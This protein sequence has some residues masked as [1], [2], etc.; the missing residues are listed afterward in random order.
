M[1][2]RQL[3]YL[4]VAA[5][6]II[7]IASWLGF[8]RKPGGEPSAPL[9]PELKGQ[10]AKVTAVKIYKGNEQLLVEAARGESGW[11]IKQ[12]FDYAGD[13]SKINGLLLAL[14][15]ATLLEEKTSNPDNY[16]ALGVQDLSADATG[17]RIELAGVEPPIKLIVGKSATA[18]SGTYVRRAGE[19]K[20]WLIGKQLNAPADA[21]AW[22]KRDLLDIG[23]DRV[24]EAQ[25]QVGA[26]ARYTAAKAQRADANFDVTPLPKGRE[27]SSVSAANAVAQTLVALQLDD[28]RPANELASEK[29]AGVAHYRTFDGLTLTV[30]GY[31]R[32]DKR[33]ITVQAAFDEASAK[34][35]HLPAAA[36]DTKNAADKQEPAKDANSLQA[37]I[38]KVRAEA[39]ALG[40]RVNGWAF[41]IPQYKYDA[42]FKPLEELLLKK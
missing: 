42:I 34:R 22:L 30:T 31:A 36:A 7:L 29:P 27:L 6:A 33:W 11:T 23:A 19:A 9:Y 41:A 14:E 24:Q 26:N 8:A 2:S 1:N 18:G 4:S 40:M 5:L 10:L 37:S 28:V 15:E 21:A 35:F 38:D 32:D 3:A 12:R 25:V 13:A 16:A 39:D 17:S 20:S